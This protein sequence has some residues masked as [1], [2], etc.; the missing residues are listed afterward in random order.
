MLASSW[1]WYKLWH[2]FFFGEG[3]RSRCYGRTA[4]LRLIVQPV[5]KMISFFVFPCNGAP[6]EWN[7]QGKIEVLGGKPVPVP[8]C[9]PQIPHAL[10]QD[11]TRASD[12]HDLHFTDTYAH[13]IRLNS[14][15][16]MLIFWYS[17]EVIFCT[18]ILNFQPFIY[19]LHVY[20][21]A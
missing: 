4:A 3:P 7:W 12:W 9:R 21:Y 5:M 2:Y 13:I 18:C 10:T 1:I 6:V 11:R 17:A 14:E 16:A 19:K 8:L 15:V 20:N